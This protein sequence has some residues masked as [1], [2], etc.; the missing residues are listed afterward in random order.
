MGREGLREEGEEGEGRD[1]LGFGAMR[2]AG[3]RSDAIAGGR[4]YVEETGFGIWITGKTCL[5]GCER[6]K[7]K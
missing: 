1:K 2:V 5:F 6:R 3:K 4:L 7:K